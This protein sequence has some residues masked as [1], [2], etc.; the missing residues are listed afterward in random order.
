M[1][2]IVFI[3]D[4][5]NILN[6]INRM[7]R[8]CGWKL[9]IFTSPEEALQELKLLKNVNIVVSDYRMP[10]MDGIT[11]LNSV[12]SLHPKA[13]RIILS[14]HADLRSVLE[15][16][17]QTEIYRFITKPWIDEELVITLKNAVAHQFLVDENIKLS[18]M[19]RQQQDKIH[20]QLK[21]LKRLESDSPGITHVDLNEDGY[22][23]L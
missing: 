16:I 18:H 2:T 15:A 6:A 11:L 19:V 23:A 1:T 13:L 21:E 5:P 8:N 3:D 9:L 22:L 4:E 12:K 10:N 20:N 17:N 7:L 14:G